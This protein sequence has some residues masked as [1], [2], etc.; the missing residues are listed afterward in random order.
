MLHALNDMTIPLDSFVV[1]PHSIFAICIATS[2]SES[3]LQQTSTPAFSKIIMLYTAP[4]CFS[5][6]SRLAI[7]RL[8]YNNQLR[9]SAPGNTPESPS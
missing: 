3:A 8:Q 9:G 2:E 5:Y 7:C 6:G 1:E 4:K